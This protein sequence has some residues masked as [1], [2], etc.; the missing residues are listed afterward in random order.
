MF[1]WLK[2]LAWAGADLD[3]H[4]NRYV[5]NCNVYALIVIATSLPYPFI[6]L[7]LKVDVDP[8]LLSGSV[9]FLFS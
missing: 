3:A 9:V 5:I 8:L 7:Y 6:Y 2:S 4:R 1:S